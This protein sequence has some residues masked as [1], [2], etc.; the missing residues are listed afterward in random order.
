MAALRNLGPK[1]VVCCLESWKEN[2]IVIV[3]GPARDVLSSVSF[4]TGW[5]P[6]LQDHWENQ[7]LGL[8]GRTSSGGTRRGF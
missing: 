6:T 5:L 2:F 3:G 1:K 4:V 8:G 7:E